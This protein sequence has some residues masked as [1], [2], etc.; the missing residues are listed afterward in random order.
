M[1]SAQLS[2]RRVP[3]WRA[4]PCVSVCG[5]VVQLVWRLAEIVDKQA[6]GIKTV[7][8][9]KVWLGT[10]HTPINAAVHHDFY[11]VRLPRRA[12]MHARRAWPPAPAVGIA[13]Y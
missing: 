11:K 5:R 13:V 10:Y 1:S 2:S 4:G 12:H 3:H 6:G 8:K 9:E 7:L